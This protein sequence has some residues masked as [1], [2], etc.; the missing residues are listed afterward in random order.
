[1]KYMTIF[2]KSEFL[3]VVSIIL[4]VALIS[5][6]NFIESQLKAR[7]EQRKASARSIV[8]SLEAYQKEF[9]SF[10]P[11]RDG[12]IVS[13]G[14]PKNLSPC[15][16]GKD[17]LRDLRDL[18]YPAYIDP[19]PLDPRQGQGNSFYY[20]SNG[21]EFQIFSHLER[22]MD[23]EWSPYVHSLKLPCGQERCNYGITLSRAPVKK[24]LGK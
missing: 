8:N 21:S 22:R 5:Y 7:D 20:V 3:G 9:G 10:P 18:S 23:P 19:L 14:D 4:I 13:C 1:M 15:Q 11:S 24:F 17:P 12:F 16:W 6:F 2:T